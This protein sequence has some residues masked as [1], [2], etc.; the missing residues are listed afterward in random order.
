MSCCYSN[1]GFRSLYIK[2]NLEKD[3]EME[4]IEG[5][6]EEEEGEDEE[7]EEPRANQHLGRSGRP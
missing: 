7:E 5:E 3:E 1:R 6:E 4:E 2:K